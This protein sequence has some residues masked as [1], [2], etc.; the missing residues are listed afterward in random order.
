MGIHRPI[1][2]AS[3]SPRRADLLRA[4]GIAFL[5]D[6]ADVNESVRRGEAPAGYVQRLAEEKARAVA[7]RH[8]GRVVLGADTT[9]VAGAAILGKPSGPD[10]AR[11]MLRQLSGRAHDV[12]TGVSVVEPSGR[13]L[14]QLSVSTVCVARVAEEERE[15]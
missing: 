1:V 14:T 6:V 3:A 13:A 15:W 7:A 2:L 5:V 12:L 9:V 4:A 11:A 8:P 10:D